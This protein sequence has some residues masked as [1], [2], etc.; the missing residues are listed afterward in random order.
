MQDCPACKS[1]PS[2]RKRL[3]ISPFFP[4]ECGNCGA[5]LLASGWYW[6]APAAFGLALF[7]PLLFD[8]PGRAAVLSTVA[9]LVLYLVILLFFVPLRRT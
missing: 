5:S 7:S 2:F 9:G 8:I 3:A 1:S 6:L 4:V